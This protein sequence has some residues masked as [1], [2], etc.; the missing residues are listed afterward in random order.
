MHRVWGYSSVLLGMSL[1]AAGSARGRMAMC[2]G[3]NGISSIGLVKSMSGNPFQAD[4]E[5][6]VPTGTVEIYPFRVV[7]AG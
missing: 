5:T 7:A 2:S 4:L 3:F 1:L 6:T